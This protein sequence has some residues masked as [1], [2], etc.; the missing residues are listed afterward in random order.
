MGV[1][2]EMNVTQ[3]KI[4]PHTLTTHDTYVSNASR[5]RPE[6]PGKNWSRP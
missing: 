1:S 3:G 2:V 4:R 5:N 6:Q